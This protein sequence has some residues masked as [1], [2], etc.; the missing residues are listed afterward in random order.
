MKGAHKFSPTSGAAL[1]RDREYPGTVPLR[2]ALD[3]SG[4][5]TNGE[6]VSRNATALLTRLKECHQRHHAVPDPMLFREAW[7]AIQQL[8]S[9][10]DRPTP[11][12]CWLWY[13]LAEY[14][15][16]EGHDVEWMLVHVDPRCP[17]CS[18]STKVEPSLTGYP[19]VTCASHCGRP[20]DVTI[21]VVERVVG[22]YNATFD[23]QISRF[24]LF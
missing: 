9:G 20:N 6:L 8:R 21:A 2:E 10:E 24:G 19:N 1:S 23:E 13:A 5:L 18:S 15:D 12:D 16:R 17:H 14:L 11:W 3:G 4:E 22:L 7:D